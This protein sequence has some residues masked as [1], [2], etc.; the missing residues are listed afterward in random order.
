MRVEWSLEVPKETKRALNP[1]I[2]RYLD[3]LPPWCHTLKVLPASMDDTRSGEPLD[4]KMAMVAEY[5]YRYAKM[6]VHNDWLVW[7][8]YERELTVVHEFCHVINAPLI[9]FHDQLIAILEQKSPGAKAM[10]EVL[11]E[12]GMEAATEDTAMILWR[13]TENRRA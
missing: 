12:A 4:Y 2:M 3:V 13:L 7:S 6:Y 10:L 5:Q 11:Q 8:D 1:L 9:A